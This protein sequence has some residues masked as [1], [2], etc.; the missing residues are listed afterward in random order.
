MFSLFMEPILTI[1]GDAISILQISNT[2]NIMSYLRCHSKNQGSPLDIAMLESHT[3]I[4]A[5][6]INCELKEFFLRLSL[7]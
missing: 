7:Q 6:M 2:T 1:G 3:A 5:M 4:V